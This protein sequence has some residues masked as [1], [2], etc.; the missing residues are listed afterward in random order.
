M[1]Y[2][3]GFIVRV[4]GMP[5]INLLLGFWISK[6]AQTRTWPPPISMAGSTRVTWAV[7]R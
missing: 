2:S 1:G 3:A 4:T 6:S 7:M 5:G